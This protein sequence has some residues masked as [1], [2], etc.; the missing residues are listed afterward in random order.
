MQLQVLESTSLAIAP[1]EVIRRVKALLSAIDSNPQTYPLFYGSSVTNTLEAERAAASHFVGID[2]LTLRLR[3]IRVLGA[4]GLQDSVADELISFAPHLTTSPCSR[5]LDPDVDT[6]Y[7]ALGDFLFSRER[8]M[9]ERTVNEIETTIRGA[10]SPL[11]LPGIARLLTKTPLN[12]NDLQFLIIEFATVLRKSAASDREMSFLGQTRELPDSIGGLLQR[13]RDAGLDTSEMVMS[14]RDFMVNSLGQVRCRDSMTNWPALRADLDRLEH[15]DRFAPSLST[16]A[17]TD[18]L[19]QPTTEIA[20]QVSLL[21]NASATDHLLGAM[22][23]LRSVS[24]SS[25]D[26]ENAARWDQLADQIAS[27]ADVTPAIN[28][29]DECARFFQRKVLLAAF[30]LCPNGLPRKLKLLDSVVDLLADDSAQESDP[31]LWALQ[32][33]LMANLARPVTKADETKLKR[34]TSN[35][36]FLPFVPRLPAF[37]VRDALRRAN[38]DIINGYLAA[39]V[40]SKKDF[41]APFLH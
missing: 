1:A 18:I 41:D 11:L 30:D 14:Y 9:A 3:A 34:L 13:M 32:A 16:L 37:V 39:D 28:G 5:A 31:L 33:K 40:L 38:N 23:K 36:A 21:P 2:S 26:A 22:Y 20:A 10:T 24:D 12:K 15:K 29:C 17:D 35:Q 19:R 8:P 25:D 7:A 6:Y 27:A 4:T